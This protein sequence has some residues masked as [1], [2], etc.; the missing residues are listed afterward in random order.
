M[1]T[2]LSTQGNR[3]ETSFIYIIYWGV[4]TTNS[5]HNQVFMPYNQVYGLKILA[6]MI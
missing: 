4:G 3:V 1:E 2:T 5:I 6:F